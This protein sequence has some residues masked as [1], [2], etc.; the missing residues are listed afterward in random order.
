MSIDLSATRV[1]T[2]V[3][4]SSNQSRPVVAPPSTEGPT[5][6]LMGSGRQA[7]SASSN[8]TLPGVANE[9]A[10][11]VS[12]T[13]QLQAAVSRMSDHVQSIRRGLEFSVDEGTGR[14]V[15]TVYDAESEEV[16]RQ[17]PSEEFLNLVRRMDEKMETSGSLINEQA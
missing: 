14:T 11:A 10:T 6:K 13:S 12:E 2:D 1:T 16:I 17:I 3:V 8:Q 15:I 9:E 5:I 4:Y 7:A